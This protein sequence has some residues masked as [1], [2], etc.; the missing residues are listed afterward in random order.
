MNKSS[1]EYH[2]GEL[3]IALDP[4]NPNRLLPEIGDAESILDIGCGAAQTLIAL[5]TGSRR[6]GIDIDVEALAFGVRGPAGTTDIRLV[7]A[8]GEHLPFQENSFDFVYSRVALP[9]M[10]VPVA[11]AEMH[12][13]LRSRGRLWLT[14]HPIEIPASQ[15]RRGNLKG[16]VFAVYVVLNGLWFHLSGRTFR[17][18]R[19]IRESF[20]TERGMRIALVRAGFSRVQFRRTPHHFIVTAER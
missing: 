12:R 2:E 5:D 1:I 16:K 8:R 13:V 3:R 9:Y 15:F 4:T 18:L 20:Q 7:A 10:N 19:A 17:F 11:L 14:L 6:F